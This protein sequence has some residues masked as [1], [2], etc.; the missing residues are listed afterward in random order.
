MVSLGFGTVGGYLGAVPIHGADTAAFLNLFFAN[1]TPT[2]V[3]GTVLKTTC[4]GLLIGV[5]CAYKGYHAA[6][7]A[8]GV[9]RAVNQGVVIAFASIW[10]FNAVFTTILL[11]LNPHL[12]VFK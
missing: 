8:V 9:G 6:G 12:Q 3:I 2:E 10:I 5:I 7:G 4:F 1:A 11:G